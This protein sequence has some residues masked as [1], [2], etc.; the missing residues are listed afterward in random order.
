MLFYKKTL[1]LAVSTVLAGYAYAEDKTDEAKTDETVEL[2]MVQVV[3]QATAG[4]DELITAEDLD[5]LQAQDLSDIFRKNPT[6]SAGGPVGLGQKVYVRNVGEDMLNISVDGAEQAGAVFHHSGRIAVEPEL[7]KQVEIEAGAG[8]ATAGPGALGG[9]IRFTTK[10]PMDLLHPGE[11]AGVL[12]KSGYFS[13]GDSTKN[14]ATVFAGDKQG[15]LSAMASIVGGN[16]NNVEDGN[17][18]ELV[19]TGSDKLLGYAKVVGQLNEA[20]RLSLSYE[21]LEESGDVLYRPEWK[22]SP[23]NP[24]SDTKADRN[25][26]ILNY[27][28]NNSNPLVDFSVNLYQTTNNQKRDQGPFTYEGNVKNTG[29]RIQNISVIDQHKLV[30]GIDY[31][32]DKSVLEDSQGFEGGALVDYPQVDEKGNVQGFFVQDIMT[33][34]DALTVTAGLRYDDYHL[35]DVLEQKIDDSGYS[36]NLSANYVIGGGFSVSA[37]YAQAIRGATVQDAFR[38]GSVA[39][40]KDLEAEK[41]ENTEVGIDYQ[42]DVFTFAA[43]AYHSVIK[44]SIGGDLPWSKVYTNQKEDIKT[45]GFYANAAANW[46]QLTLTAAFNTADSKR[47]GERVSRYVYSSTG[48]SIG[49]TL[50]LTADYHFSDDLQFGWSSELVNDLNNV[51]LQ[52]ADETV[53]TDK[54]GYGVHDIYA[55]WLPLSDDLL[56]F[57]FAV[58]NL[59]DRQY[60]SHASLED[61]SD[62]PGYEI[63]SGLPEAGREIRLSASLR[64]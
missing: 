37:G 48:V 61:F 64:F 41:A 52:L 17:G 55:R 60:S 50:V 31:R 26:L 12:L 32:E 10:D 24:L 7:L 43:G 6:V 11:T 30:Y 13:N 38:L 54:P 4:L 18:D 33:F 5:K 21:A 44:D 14:S 36:P 53:E 8:S 25:T 51:K 59:F 63:I 62:N 29:A 46:D 35:E 58:K 16:F 42:G 47:D 28:F 40:D 45:D 19:G 9:A 22:P 57:N 20:N 23:K 39:N 1:A 2:S 49:D 34:S 3:G 15:D 56:T 27:G